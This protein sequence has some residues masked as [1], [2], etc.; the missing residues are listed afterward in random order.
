M[1]RVENSRTE[2]VQ[3]GLEPKGMYWDMPV[4][5]SFDVVALGPPGHYLHVQVNDTSGSSYPRRSDH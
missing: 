2:T 1:I 3:F 5:A 4:G